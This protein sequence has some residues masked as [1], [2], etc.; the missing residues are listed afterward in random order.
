M[1]LKMSNLKIKLIFFLLLSFTGGYAQ[2]T[3]NLMEKS[4]TQTPFT[5]NSV[6]KLTFTGGNIT[7]NKTDGN[8]ITYVLG[9]IQYLSFIDQT[10][11]VSEMV[12]RENSSLLIYPNP[13]INQ[14]QICY[15]SKNSGNVQVKITNIQGVVF[16]Q[17]TTISQNGTNHIMIPVSELPGGLYICQ[18]LKGNKTESIKFLKH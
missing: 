6:R 5:L 7:V 17:Q 11:I 4:G 14:L 18:L 15:L 12:N 1:N 2:N 10:S 9:D 3:L 16:H 13:V 8:S